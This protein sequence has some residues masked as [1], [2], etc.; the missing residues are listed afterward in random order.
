MKQKWK[1]VSK[2]FIIQH[3]C[4]AIS[5][6]KIIINNKILLLY[7]YI[8]IKYIYIF[9]LKIILFKKVLITV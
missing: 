8:K 4:L 2:Y 3:K 6:N 5:S 1:K 9:C 7:F